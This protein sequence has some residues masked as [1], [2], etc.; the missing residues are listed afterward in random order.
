LVSSNQWVN[1]DWLL[2]LSDVQ[3][4]MRQGQSL[5]VNEIPQLEGRN[6]R[7]ET[8]EAEEEGGMAGSLYSGVT[9]FR[10]LLGRD[11]FPLL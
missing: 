1:I 5:Q 10:E 7:G 6:L 2:P 11:C 4:I 9:Q 8:W 3:K